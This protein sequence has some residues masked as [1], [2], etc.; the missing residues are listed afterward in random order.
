VC[1]VTHHNVCECVCRGEITG[2]IIEGPPPCSPLLMSSY[3][4]TEWKKKE[5][6]NIEKIFVLIMR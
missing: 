6:K 4:E 1:N 5:K 3:T 2:P